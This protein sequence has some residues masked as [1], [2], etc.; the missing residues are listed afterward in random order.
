MQGSQ[1]LANHLLPYVLINKKQT[2]VIRVSSKGNQI[3]TEE[4]E[5]L[6]KFRHSAENVRFLSKICNMHLCEPFG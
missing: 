5:G 6:Y 1:G 4:F 2:N 3:V